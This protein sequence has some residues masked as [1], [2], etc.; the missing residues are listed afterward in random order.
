M[1]LCRRYLNYLFCNERSR[2]NKKAMT[3][4]KR[5]EWQA[6]L[7]EEK[8]EED[9][10]EMK[11][12]LAHNSLFLRI[13]TQS[14]NNFYHSKLIWGL[15]FEP[16]IVLDCGY[17]AYMNNM[18]NHNCAKQLTLAFA[19]NR[20]HKNPMTLYYCNLNE[21]GLLRR[22][23][24]R[25]MPNLL[26]DDF[27]AFVTSQSYLD[28]FP[29]DQLVYLTPHCREDMIEYDPD[30]VYIIGAIVDKVRYLDKLKGEN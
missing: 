22:N 23:F 26:D 17:E 3:E 9:T 15:M 24:Q 6:K 2:E 10:D 18:E 30:M 25:N 5:Q 12:G 11:Y 20:I 4:Q 14:I 7:A 29:K 19:A 8:E 28:L 13:Y 27:P 21:K 1:P 16:K